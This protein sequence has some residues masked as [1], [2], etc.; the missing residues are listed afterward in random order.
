MNFLLQFSAIVVEM[1]VLFIYLPEGLND[2]G[3]S[4]I[5]GSVRFIY[6]RDD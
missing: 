5:G 6:G 2:E 4:F 1:N 3:H